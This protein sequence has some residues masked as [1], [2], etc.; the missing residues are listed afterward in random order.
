MKQLVKRP[1]QILA[2]YDHTS[3]RAFQLLRLFLVAF[4]YLSLYLFVKVFLITFKLSLV[5]F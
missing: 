2:S 4:I 3:W 1:L 5:D